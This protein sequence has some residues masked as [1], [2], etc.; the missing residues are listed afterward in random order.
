MSVYMCT[1]FVYA[2]THTVC[3]CVS[4]CEC[5]FFFMALC[6]CVCGGG[7]GCV[8]WGGVCV[9]VLSSLCV[10]V[11]VYV[12]VCVCGWIGWVYQGEGDRMSLCVQVCLW[13]F[14]YRVKDVFAADT[15]GYRG[16]ARLASAR[17][18]MGFVTV[19]G[20]R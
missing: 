7:G 2:H 11:A 4:S 9:C 3:V 15:H 8:V 14:E 6:V 12:C 18:L 13:F 16:G 5:V 19:G 17:R 10:C 1:V 20:M